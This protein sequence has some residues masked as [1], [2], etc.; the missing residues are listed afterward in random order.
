MNQSVSGEQG[1]QT[2]NTSFQRRHLSQSIGGN[3]SQRILT[4]PSSFMQSPMQDGTATLSGET[5]YINWGTNINTQECSNKFEKFLLEFKAI[6][7]DDHDMLDENASEVNI[8]VEKFNQMAALEQYILTFDGQHLLQFDK[9]L[10]YQL[11]FFPAEVIQIFDKVAQSIFRERFAQNETQVEKSNSVLVAV[12]NINKSTQLRDLRHK[13]INRLVSIK[14]IVIR[15]SDI[16]PEMKMAVFKCS[17]C[18][19]SVIVP[20]ERA[21]VDEPNDC[22]S[23]HTKNSFMIQ[24]NLSHFTDKQ[25][26]KIQ[27]LPEKVREGETPQ[28]ATLMAYDNNLVD[29]VKPGDRVEVV[30]VFRAAGVRKNKNIR[31]LRSVYNTYIDVVS[32]SLLSK[33]KLQEEKINF[34]EETK[35][36]LQEIADSENVYDKLIKSVAPSIWENTDVKR[37]LL[38]Q[39]FGGSVKTIHDAKDSRTRAEIN[40]LLVGDPSVAKSQMLKYVH[41]LVPRGI[42]TSGKGSSAVGLT[43]Y[44]T[45]DPDTKEIV[46]ES[47]ALVLSDLGICCIDE[48]DKMDENTRTIL[49]E[50]MEQQSISIAKAGIVATLNTRTA[51]LAGANPIDSR[52]DPKKSVID[53]INLPPSLL[54]RFDLIYILLDNHDERKDIQLASHILKLFSNSSQHRLTQGQNSGYSD[55]DIID[56]D[57]LIKYIAYARQEIHPKLTQEAADRLVQG[58]VDMRK[59][60]LSNKVIT[61][62][63]RQLESLIRISESLAK[64]KLSDQVTVENVEEAIRLMKVATQSAATDPTTGLIDMDMLATGI[65]AQK[66]QRILDLS[67][68]IRGLAK[69]NQGVFKKG[70]S[71]HE[72]RQLLAN[73]ENIQIIKIDEQEVISAVNMLVEEN[74]LLK[75]GNNKNPIIKLQ[76]IEE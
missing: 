1:K 2:P 61:S 51:I 36:K 7:S 15:V 10:Y 58:Y 27:E 29:Q 56:K 39:L 64:M 34:S 37:G 21:H 11:I 74:L 24:H 4:Q 60:G 62:T 46:L 68:Q 71:V 32:Y 70:I 50:A 66:K 22:E 63:T 12:V 76:S 26:I 40:C 16:Y 20:L 44:V 28:T 9:I 45:R 41:N 8:Y 18:S 19:H 55:I 53:N 38:C 43:A 69:S 47:G 49:H 33:Q 48:F 54:S 35:R 72:L 42:Y 23:C 3:Q 25:Y 13:D 65:S 67:D 31:T 17:R 30:G 75:M 6:P 14:C 52:Y 5:G 73:K 59:V 57:T